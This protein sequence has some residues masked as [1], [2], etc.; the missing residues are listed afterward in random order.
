MHNKLEK[1][2]SKGRGTLSGFTC[3]SRVLHFLLHSEHMNSETKEA[4]NSLCLCYRHNASFFF[5]CPASPSRVEERRVLVFGMGNSLA[6]QSHSSACWESSSAQSSGG[7]G[8]KCAHSGCC[9]HNTYCFYSTYSQLSYFHN[10]E[11]IW[12]IKFINIYTNRLLTG[13]FIY[14]CWFS[15]QANSII[16]IDMN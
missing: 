12:R 9:V 13:F 11:Y 3:S 15:L 8:H 14:F 4:L 7:L 1:I 10:L 2:L 5:G 6:Q 16:F